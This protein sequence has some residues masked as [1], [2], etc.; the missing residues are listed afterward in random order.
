MT[1]GCGA[2]TQKRWPYGQAEGDLVEGG[3]DRADLR[4]DVDAV[5]VLLDHAFHAA[6]LAF[7]AP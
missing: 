4:E 6:N 3:L 1:K 7:H 5:A 2:S